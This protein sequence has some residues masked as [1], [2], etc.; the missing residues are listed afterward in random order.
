MIDQPD[1]PRHQPR[2][3]VNSDI[4]G[5]LDLVGRVYAEYGC[6]FKPE[7]D[8]PFLLD[9]GPY[10]RPDGGEFWVVEADDAVQATG[11]CKLHADA[12]ELKT[13]YVDPRLRRRGVGAALTETA[14]R[15]AREAGRPR[16]FLWTDTRFVDAHRLYRK[17]GF[18][19][20]GERD[21]GD[22]NNSRE[23]GFELK[24]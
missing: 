11:A 4:P 10:F 24:R 22:L 15:H 17:L 23:F 1:V 6:V 14:I 21:L 5:V 3:L 7:V 13:L 8:D 2:P 9:P 18:V 12:G 16:F 20:F 19:Q